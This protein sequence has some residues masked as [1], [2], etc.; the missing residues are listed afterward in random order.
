MKA[1]F[2]ELGRWFKVSFSSPWSQHPGEPG[3]LQLLR[4]TVLRQRLLLRAR[5]PGGGAGG[6]AAEGRA[7]EGR[8]RLLVSAGTARPHGRHGSHRR[9]HPVP[10]LRG[11]CGQGIRQAEVGDAFGRGGQMR[12][13]G[14]CYAPP[15]PSVAQ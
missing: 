14:L 7:G 9:P 15:P 6:G 3:G 1:M 2:L 5:R 12:R 11:R 10:T 13:R 4:A 8:L